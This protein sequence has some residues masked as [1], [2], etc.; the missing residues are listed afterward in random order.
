MIRFLF[1]EMDKF[2]FVPTPGRLARRASMAN[3]IQEYDTPWNLIKSK[4]AFWDMV[5]QSG[6]ADHLVETA[7]KA[8]GEGDLVEI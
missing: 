7:R 5:Q 6:E 8:A 2:W 1:L 3:I 4:G